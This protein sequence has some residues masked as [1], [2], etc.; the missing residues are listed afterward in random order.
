[1]AL[2]SIS[3]V[4][5]LAL[6]WSVAR[7]QDDF[8]AFDDFG[9][10]WEESTGGLQWTGFLEAAYGRRLAGEPNF[11]SRQTLGDVRSRLETVWTADKLS[12]TF[13]G[14]ALYDDY[15][16]DLDAAVRELNLQFSLTKSIDM[17]IGRQVLTWG[18]GDLLFLNDLFPKSWVSFFSGRD[19]DYLKAPSDAVRATWYGP[20]FGVDAVLSPAFNADEYLTGERFSFFSGFVGGV[21]APEVPLAVYKPQ[22]ELRNSE[23]AVRVFWS[24][25]SIEYAAYVYRGFFKQPLGFDSELNL[26]FPEL[27]VYGGSLRRPLASGIFNAEFAFHD[28]RDDNGGVDPSVP[29]SQLRLLLGYEFEARPRLTIGFQYYLEWI[30]QYSALIANS[31]TP[32]FEPDNKR[33]VF[34]NRATFR[35]NREKLTVSLFSFLSVSD[36]DYYLRPSVS[37]RH[38]D[39]WVVTG[40]ANV[41]RGEEVHT[42]FGQLEDNSNAYVRVRFSF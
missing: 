8:S 2:R 35:T 26:V 7:A 12:L 31:L 16:S 19:D 39:R 20:R 24:T 36:R 9:S 13:K 30:Q 29:N 18:T 42:F 41:F 37:Y 4:L 14:E 28:S 6:Q 33:H 22:R 17:K 32:Q 5:L 11:Q 27:S 34:T 38:S 23:L 1:M 15:A 40:G 3:F 21:F 10:E 25:G